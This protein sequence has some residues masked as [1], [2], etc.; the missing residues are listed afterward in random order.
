[1]FVKV[2]EATVTLLTRENPV[3]LVQHLIESV[4]EE[5]LALVVLLCCNRVS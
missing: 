5:H 3:C 4:S 1:M 2:K